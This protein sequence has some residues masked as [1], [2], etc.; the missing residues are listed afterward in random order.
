ME[1]CPLT[2]NNIV[3]L[4]HCPIKNKFYWLLFILTGPIEIYLSKEEKSVLRKIR[5]IH[6][7]KKRQTLRA[8]VILFL[9]LGYSNKE[10]A[11]M[12]GMAVPKVGKWR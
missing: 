4:L 12:I 3:E 2:E 1:Q 10:I 7:S 9:D 8:K 11:K 5:R 6:K